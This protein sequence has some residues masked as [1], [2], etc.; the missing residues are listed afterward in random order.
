MVHGEQPRVC[1]ELY[2][3]PG[4]HLCESALEQLIDALKDVSFDLVE[5]NIND[6]ADWTKKYAFDIPVVAVNGKV[7]CATFLNV[8]AFKTHIKEISSKT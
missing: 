5:C 3:K 6:S 7:F 1:V 8:E 4:C 2:S